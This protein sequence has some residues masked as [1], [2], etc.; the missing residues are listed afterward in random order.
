MFMN[1]MFHSR[2]VWVALIVAL[3]LVLGTR[4]LPAGA[5]AIG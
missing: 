2:L 3:A 4:F 5:G 1:R